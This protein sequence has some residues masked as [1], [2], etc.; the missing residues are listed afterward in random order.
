LR[1]GAKNER[2]A[3]FRF[4]GDFRERVPKMPAPGTAKDYQFGEHSV[5]LAAQ[6][7]VS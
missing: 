4:F 6:Q 5:S 3:S 2:L 7:C 1:K